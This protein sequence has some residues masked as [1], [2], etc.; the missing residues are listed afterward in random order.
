[1]VKICTKTFEQITEMV[2]AALVLVLPDFEK[3]FTVECDASNV[4]IRAILSQDGRPV[5]CFSEKLT[6]A[7]RR[8]STYD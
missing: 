7:K 2:T 5:E 6:G 4:G 3:L 8:Y 1:M